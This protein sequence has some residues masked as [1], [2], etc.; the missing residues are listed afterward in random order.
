MPVMHTRDGT[1][2]L[3]S[4]TFRRTLTFA[5]AGKVNVRHAT[6]FLQELLSAVSRKE[7]PRKPKETTQK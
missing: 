3:G 1:T 5:L 2:A 7:N 4:R 6:F